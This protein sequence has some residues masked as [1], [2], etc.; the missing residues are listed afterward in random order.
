MKA[1]MNHHGSID[2]GLHELQALNQQ[3]NQPKNVKPNDFQH[4]LTPMED[5]A[6]D[7]RFD[8]AIRSTRC[9]DFA[10][11]WLLF[12]PALLF[13]VLVACHWLLM[14]ALVAS[15]LCW[16][17]WFVLAVSGTVHMLAALVFIRLKTADSDSVTASPPIY[18]GLLII[19]HF[20]A[21]I[22]YILCI[23]LEAPAQCLLTSFKEK[24]ASQTLNASIGN[25]CMSKNLSILFPLYRELVVFFSYKSA[26]NPLWYS[27]LNT[28][29]EWSTPINF[30]KVS[31]ESVELPLFVFVLVDFLV[32]ASAFCVFVLETCAA[33]HLHLRSRPLYSA[34]RARF[35]GDSR[36]CCTYCFKSFCL[37]PLCWSLAMC[38]WALNLRVYKPSGIIHQ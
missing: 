4:C 37:A 11:F 13:V 23:T 7:L 16:W 32:R 28:S 35:A 29:R 21:F 22:I 34:V 1:A 19:V 38:L 30:F 33:F 31:N 24:L 26:Q 14:I 17:P 10:W 36:D 25:S 27:S 20:V 8:R 5:S 12:L 2:S 3:S 15:G 6:I 9:L 18:A